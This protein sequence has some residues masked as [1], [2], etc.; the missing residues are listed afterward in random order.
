[1]LDIP[2]TFETR[3][4]GYAPQNYDL[5][6]RGMVT[7]RTALASSLNVPAVGMLE[8]L[9]VEPFVDELR[10]LGISTLED[11]GRY[12]L[13]LALGAGEVSLLELSAAYGVLANGGASVEPFAVTRVR[14]T[15]GNVLYERRPPDSHAVIPEETAFIVSDILADPVAREP[16]FGRGSALEL[17]FAAAVKT[18]TTTDF[19]DNW[20]VGYTPRQVVGVWVGNADNAPMRDVSGV[21]GAAPIWAEVM[22]AARLIQGD[23]AFV[24]PATVAR[25]EVCPPTELLPGDAC[26]ATSSE[27]FIAG[28][29]PRETEQY[30][31]RDAAGRTRIDPPVAARPWLQDGGHLLTET[32]RPDEAAVRVVQPA[33]GSVLFVAPEL[34][35]Q[36]LVVRVGCPPGAKAVTVFADGEAIGSHDS[37]RDRIVTALTPGEHE[38]RVEVR[39][40]TGQVL[41]AHSEYEVR[42]Q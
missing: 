11:A 30:Y 21:A 28:S 31:V 32:A 36:E 40:A 15:A 27:W 17:P 16:G 25:V 19:R 23:E 37:C 18:G 1:V 6:F 2:T 26:P 7:L 38:L 12:G 29:E 8:A 42:T 10:R 14:D 9:G 3:H 5:A 24:A 39:L 34:A 20:T 33:P 41:L 22:V 4:G 35:Q 13:A